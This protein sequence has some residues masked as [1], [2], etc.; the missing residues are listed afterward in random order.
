LKTKDLGAVL[1]RSLRNKDLR[2]K[3]FKINKLWLVWQ[4]IPRGFIVYVIEE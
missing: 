2:V 1:A 3:Y 4:L